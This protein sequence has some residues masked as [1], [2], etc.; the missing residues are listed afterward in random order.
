MTARWS[1]FDDRQVVHFRRPPNGSFSVVVHPIQKFA[2]TQIPTAGIDYKVEQFLRYSDSE[3][4]NFADKFTLGEIG[5]GTGCVEYCLIDRTSGAVFSGLDFNQDFPNDYNGPTGF[6]YRRDSRLFIVYH[7][8]AFQ[9]PV[10]VSYYDWSG[11]N[12]TLLETND[13]RAQK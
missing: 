10:H 5:C 6:Y 13:I 3:P 1:I 4:L 7:A 11:T 2:H 8:T 12:M 9:Y